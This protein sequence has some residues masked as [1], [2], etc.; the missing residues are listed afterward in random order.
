[1]AVFPGFRMMRQPDDPEAIFRYHSNQTPLPDSRFVGR[2]YS[3]YVNSDFDALVDRFLSTIPHGERMQVLRQ[4]VRHMSE[5][6]TVMGMFY[7]ADITFMNARVTNV[8]ARQSN[9]WNVQ[10]W[11]VSG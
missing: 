3:R 8:G 10:Q 5:N 11:D 4:I 6:V 1:M 9:L 7:D 2:N